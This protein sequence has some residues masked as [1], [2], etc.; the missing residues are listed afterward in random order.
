M[1]NLFPHVKQLLWQTSEFERAAGSGCCQRH[2]PSAFSKTHW[3]LSCLLGM[4]SLS[5]ICPL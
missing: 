4:G 1:Q 5:E 2:S 3:L